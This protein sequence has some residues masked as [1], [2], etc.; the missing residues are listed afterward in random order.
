M[1]GGQEATRY[2]IKV[3]VQFEAETRIRAWLQAC[4]QAQVEAQAFSRCA[5]TGKPRRRKPF[6]IVALAGIAEAMP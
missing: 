2:R 5:V 6:R 4:R 3:I 1:G